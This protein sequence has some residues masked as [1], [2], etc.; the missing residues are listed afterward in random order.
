[1]SQGIFDFV[2]HTL[3]LDVL[4]ADLA[5]SHMAWR[6]LV[7]AVW[8]LVLLNL[9]HKRFLGRNSGSDILVGVVLGSVLSRAIN[10]QAAFFPTLGVCAVL[11]LL[12]R[13]LMAAAFH[14]HRISLLAKGRDYVL[15]RNGKIDWR[16]MRRS[17]ITE[18]DLLENLRINGNVGRIA[19]VSEARLERN[20]TISVTK[21]SS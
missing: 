4:S 7:V 13:A 18:D 14:S 8:S 15:V 2:S 16:E 3:G 11:V 12:H 5:F 19:D 1:M 20:G 17:R 6:A 9:A 10:G 21:S